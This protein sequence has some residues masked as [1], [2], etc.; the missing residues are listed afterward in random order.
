K[1]SWVRTQE[2]VM[3]STSRELAIDLLP[4]CAQI[5]QVNHT[6]PGIEVTG[7]VDG[8]F[9]PEGPL[10]FEVLLDMGMLVLDVETGVDPIGDDPGAVAK[11]RGGRSF[12]EPGGKEQAHPVGAA[13]IQV[14]PDQLFEEVASLDRLVKYVGEAYLQL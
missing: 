6:L 11:R 4:G 5:G 13:Q 14:L 3:R 10:L 1:A 8:G 12:R 2:P 9:R 7:I